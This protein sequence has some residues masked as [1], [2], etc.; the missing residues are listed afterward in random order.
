M[1]LTRAHIFDLPI[2]HL[3]KGVGWKYIR[4]KSQFLAVRENPFQTASLQVFKVIFAMR[5]IM[6]QKIYKSEL[7]PVKRGKKRVTV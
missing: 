2:L 6:R 1:K 4:T 3:G 7:H 5:D